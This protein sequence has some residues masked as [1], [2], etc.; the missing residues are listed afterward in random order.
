MDDIGHAAFHVIV[1]IGKSDVW[2]LSLPRKL[3]AR[4][5]GWCV[6]VRRSF[7]AGSCVTLLIFY[8]PVIVHVYHMCVW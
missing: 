3:L 2:S 4:L 1:P 6:C 8:Q 7:M 5:T